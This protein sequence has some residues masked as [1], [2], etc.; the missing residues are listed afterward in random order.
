MKWLYPF[1][2]HMLKPYLLPTGLYLEIGFCKV[3]RVRLGLRDDSLMMGLVAL[4]KR[5]E[6][7]TSLSL[8]TP[9]LPLPSSLF[10]LVQSAGQVCEQIERMWSA[11]PEESSSWELSGMAS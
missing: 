7:K 4:N 9:T 6:K 2:T 1:K 11:N 10:I 5:E 3:I 8:P